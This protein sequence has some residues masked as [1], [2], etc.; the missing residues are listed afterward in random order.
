MGCTSVTGRLRYHRSW[1]TYGCASKMR[2]SFCT[3]VFGVDLEPLVGNDYI[4]HGGASPFEETRL[5][6]APE[7]ACPSF[8]L[9]LR[10]DR[11]RN[12]LDTRLC[13]KHKLYKI[14]GIFC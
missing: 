8:P 2:S 13:F 1:P 14:A 11:L 5:L 7:H 4:V 12:R 3:R 9:P 10:M 6:H